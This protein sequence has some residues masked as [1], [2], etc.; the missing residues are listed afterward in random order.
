MKKNNLD[1][2]QEQKLLHIEHNCCCLAF[3][4]LVLSITIQGLLSCYLDHILGEII[5][6]FILCIYMVISCLKQGIWDRKLLP[7]RKNNALCSLVASAFI[8]VFS[9]FMLS[10]KLVEEDK[11]LTITLALMVFV[12]L[13]SMAALSICT[14]IYKKKH[15]SLEKE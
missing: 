10:G 9:F 2:M 3:W 7:S 14:A 15:D 1:E 6:L 4:L 11:L 12:F 5:C 13:L 8:G